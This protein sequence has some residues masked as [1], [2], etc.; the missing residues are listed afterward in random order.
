MAFTWV[1]VLLAALTRGGV[2]A[3]KPP[4]CTAKTLPSKVTELFVDARERGVYEIG[5]G[6]RARPFR[7]VHE[8]RDALRRGLGANT[9]R[10]VRLVGRHFLESP[11]ELDARDSGTKEH[12][13]V[14]TSADPVDPASLSG[15][16]RV[17]P[18]AW[19]AYNGGIYVADL[20]SLG[21]NAS[22]LGKLA[23]PYPETKLELFYNG[24]PA[25]IARDPNINV[26]D[27][28]WIWAGYENM[29]SINSTSFRLRDSRAG[30]LWQKALN[31]EN[32]EVWLHGYFKFDWRD[33]YIKLDSITDNV[34][35]GQGDGNTSFVLTRD[36][37]TPP[38]YPWA[39]G[40]R[41]YALN[42][43]DLLDQAGEYFVSNDGKLFFYPPGSNGVE[44]ETVVSLQKSIIHSVGAAHISFS[45][46]HISASQS[47]GVEISQANDVHIC[48]STVSNTGGNCISLEGTS[49]STSNSTLFG[50][51]SGGIAINGG[52][53]TSLESSNISVVGNTMENFS[54]IIRTYRPAVGFNGCGHYVANNS[55]FNAPHTGLQGGGVNMLFEFNHLRNMCYETVDVGAFYVGRS[56]AQRGN[57]ARF[58]TFDVVRATERLA[59]KSCS[60]NAFYL[61]DEMSGWDIYGNVFSN[62]SQGVLLG[63]GR[64]NQIHDNLFLSNNI[65]VAF[66]NRGMNW[67]SKFCQFNCSASLGTSCA[68]LAL[69]AV[70]YQS[71]P[72]SVVFPEVVD[73]YKDHPCVPV[74]NIIE[75]N[76]WCHKNSPP[77][78]TPSFLDRN[79]SVIKSWLS[80]SSNNVENCDHVDNPSQWLL[81]QVARLQ[82]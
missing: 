23:N 53:T 43:L 27:G 73:I 39:N 28:Q 19:S 15:G 59:Q 80:M 69:E 51:G 21:L 14:Y 60:Q 50:C 64:R 30:Q 70:R 74:G 41:F 71:P 48:H 10:V 58:N 2:L 33:T 46:L 16:V 22:D 12:E 67:Q 1:V 49:C 34:E 25:T 76:T 36:V 56:W 11:L 5:V 65:D 45:K 3:R 35:K 62:A 40:C 81:N 13:I 54:R 24:K 47:T 7:S 57:V 79:A 61:D 18:E 32:G 68:R 42:N 55:I 6:T 38:Q 82:K 63:G 37:A 72:W 31:Q 52:N 4:G 77:G 9:T 8:A 20:F 44:F 75:D 26:H 29:T 17:P 78:A 66:D